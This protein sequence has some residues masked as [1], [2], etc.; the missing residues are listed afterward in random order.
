L[1]DDN[2]T[3]CETVSEYLT[4]KGYRLILAHNGLQAIEET[5]EKRPNIIL[6][7]VQMPTLDGL[8][9]MRRIRSHPK[10]AQ[11]PIIALTALAMAGDEARCLQAGANDYLS[12]T[13]Q[14][15]R[16][17]EKIEAL[18]QIPIE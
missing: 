7:D 9:A 10:I 5:L 1:A 2:L 8:D 12:K 17:S 11:T 16:V 13:L 6:M 14:F 15:Q 18:L 4:A 3:T